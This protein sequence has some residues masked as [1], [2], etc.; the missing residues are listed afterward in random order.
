[1]TSRVAAVLL[2]CRNQALAERVGGALPPP[3]FHLSTMP[4]IEQAKALMRGVH[5][6]AA[7]LFWEPQCLELL[8]QIK[9]ISRVPVC[10]IGAKG[11][12]GVGDQILAAG[13]DACLADPFHPAHLAYRLQ[14]MLWRPDRDTPA[15]LR[16]GRLRLNP[17]AFVAFW[18]D[19]EIRLGRIE[20]R[21]LELFLLHHGETLSREVIFE[22]IWPD[23]GYAL[24]RMVDVHVSN[25]RKALARDAGI[26]PLK[27]VRGAGYRMWVRSEHEGP[28]AAQGVDA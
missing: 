19:K 23:G 20:F 15:S 25:L 28:M 17:A 24:G 16:F 5:F 8:E 11:G 3:L 9:V 10:V 14:K 13:A 6:D 21:L 12:I 27:T 7:V 22:A 1:M 18:N 26:R 2:V 4:T